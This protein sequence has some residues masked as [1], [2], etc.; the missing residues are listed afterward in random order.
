MFYL[1]YV[2]YLIVSI[3]DLCIPL[4]FVTATS[5]FLKNK[6]ESRAFLIPFR[7]MRVFIELLTR[8]AMGSAM[9]FL[10]VLIV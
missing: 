5:F 7:K 9:V 1:V 3:P 10:Y 6:S 2:W 4:Y 8:S